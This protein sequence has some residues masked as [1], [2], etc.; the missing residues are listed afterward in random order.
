MC[1]MGPLP[2]GRSNRAG[3]G[4]EG[5]DPARGPSLS[6][7]VR[8]ASRSTK[9]RQIA[10]MCVV[11]VCVCVSVCLCVC[12]SVCLCVCVCVCIYVSVSVCFSVP[13][14]VSLSLSPSL[15][16]SLSLPSGRVPS[17]CARLVCRADAPRPGAP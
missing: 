15:S 17:R 5:D 7:S 3:S 12:L 16:P 2:V 6:E 11:C 1:P 4:P 13:V 8:V 14:S 9:L 10:G